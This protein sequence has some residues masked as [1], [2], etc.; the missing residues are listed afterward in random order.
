MAELEQSINRLEDLERE[1]W[2]LSIVLRTALESLQPTAMIIDRTDIPP[3][4]QRVLAEH[5]GGTWGL[6]GVAQEG[7][8]SKGKELWTRIR[9][10]IAESR[11][12]WS[13]WTAS[14][15]DIHAKLR[16]RGQKAEARAHEL[17]G[18]SPI[19]S[20]LT[21]L[22]F[23]RN[24]VRD[25]QLNSQL[26][27]ALKGLPAIMPDV[28]RVSNLSGYINNLQRQFKAARSIRDD[29][30]HEYITEVSA[31][32]FKTQDVVFKIL[33]REAKTVK[34]GS[35]AQFRQYDQIC[36]SPEY[37]GDW[38]VFY[39]CKLKPGSKN[40]LDQY[41]VTDV[42]GAPTKEKQPPV[43]KT[44]VAMDADECLQVLRGIEAVM[45]Y[46]EVIDRAVEDII[47]QAKI[48]DKQGD[49]L[50]LHALKAEWSDSQK[51]EI[52]R[53]VKETQ[54]M[55]ELT[56]RPYQ[57]VGNHVAKTLSGALFYVE[58]SLDNLG[59]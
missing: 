9:V 26:G 38:S 7:I 30:V 14:L 1:M 5:L 3:E 45:P 36:Q 44:A 39:L 24:M 12:Q 40:Q 43:D 25:G 50:L 2:D 20:D 37:P 34:P 13:E 51:A 42:V 48:I 46:F 47:N 54:R 35:R 8:G 6:T 57:L 21:R 15:T 49:Q 11:A 4:L 29:K 58:R 27:E 55:I 17:K 19:K 22:R 32:I 56:Y 10:Q 33:T 31:E 28:G 23:M 59:E 52:Y 41:R 53:W 18:L 16:R